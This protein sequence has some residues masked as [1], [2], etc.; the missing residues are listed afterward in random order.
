MHPVFV[1][2]GSAPATPILFVNEANY[3]EASKVLDAREA[4]FVKATGFAPKVGKHLIVQ[5]PDGG[6]GGILFGI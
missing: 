6:I 3:A 1:K 5:G 4:A 2:A